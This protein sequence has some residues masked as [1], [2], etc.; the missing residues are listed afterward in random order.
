MYASPSA[1]ATGLPRCTLAPDGRSGRTTAY[2]WL[3]PAVARPIFCSATLRKTSDTRER[4]AQFR[5]ALIA[6][7]GRR[8]TAVVL[9]GAPH[10][11]RL[12]VASLHFSNPKAPLLS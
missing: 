1:I 9:R 3:A 10:N 7:N 4:C 2:I 6:H 11:S 5:S 8:Y 12:C